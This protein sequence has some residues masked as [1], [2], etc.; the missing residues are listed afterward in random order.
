MT[1]EREE[2]GRIKSNRKAA[3]LKVHFVYKKLIV[4]DHERR[5]DNEL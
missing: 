3:A 5:V 2:E 1:P 4:T